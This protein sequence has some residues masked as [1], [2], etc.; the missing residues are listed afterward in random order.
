MT[1]QETAISREKQS[2][3]K[4]SHEKAQAGKP[5]TTKL[6]LASTGGRYYY[7]RRYRCGPRG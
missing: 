6:K 5:A 7:S 4:E 2:E 3:E 1:D